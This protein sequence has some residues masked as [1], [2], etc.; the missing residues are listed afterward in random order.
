[1]KKL[2]VVLSFIF[3]SGASLVSL[4][5]QR[6]AIVDVNEILSQMDSYQKAQNELE[7]IASGWRQEISQKMDEVKS[8]YNKYQAEQV[9]L[10]EE[11]KRKA[12]DEITNKEA[13]VRDLQRKRFGPDGDLFA[14]T[15][16]LVAPIQEN[17]ASAIKEYADSRGYD[18]IL[19]KSSATG[20]LFSNE[21]LDKTEEVKRQLGI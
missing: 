19:D 17:V 18:L 15:E 21:S 16:Q 8:L 2:L 6:I 7:Q 3:F 10:T 11:M 1:M 5:A 13:E 20:I 9:L 14:K 4:Q 12:E